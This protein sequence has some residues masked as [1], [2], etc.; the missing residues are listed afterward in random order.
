MLAGGPAACRAMAEAT[1]SL[2]SARVVGNDIVGNGNGEKKAND[3][4]NGA[5]NKEKNADNELVDLLHLL[6]SRQV[7][8]SRVLRIM[9]TR[10]GISC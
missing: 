1:A 8:P 10:N 9:W 5:E 2:A 6:L 4:G 7:R 3:D